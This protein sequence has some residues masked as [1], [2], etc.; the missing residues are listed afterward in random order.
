MNVSVG[1]LGLSRTHIVHR[2]TRQSHFWLGLDPVCM[3]QA[4]Q[5]DSFVFAFERIEVEGRGDS[6]SGAVRRCWSCLGH[7]SWG[8]GGTLIGR[9]TP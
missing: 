2:Q 1:S 4:I 9:S 8:C 7:L 6:P 3:T 5:S